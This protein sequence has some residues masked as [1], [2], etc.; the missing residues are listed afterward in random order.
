MTGRLRVKRLSCGAGPLPAQDGHTQIGEVDHAGEVKQGEDKGDQHQAFPKPSP[1][2]LQISSPRSHLRRLPSP[3]NPSP[4]LNRTTPLMIARFLVPLV[5]AKLLKLRLGK[6]PFLSPTAALLG[7][8]PQVLLKPC[9]H[10]AGGLDTARIKKL[11]YR[12]P[13]PARGGA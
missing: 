1:I 13:P 3:P 4:L 12:A 11:P 9:L 6:S 2:T 10:A 5:S 8:G 7:T